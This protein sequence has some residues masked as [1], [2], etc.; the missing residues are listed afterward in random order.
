MARAAFHNT[1]ISAVRRT[2]EHKP[3]YRASESAR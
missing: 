1:M 3:G 2:A